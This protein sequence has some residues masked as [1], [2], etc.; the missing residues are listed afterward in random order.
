[1]DDEQVG[2]PGALGRRDPVSERFGQLIALGRRD[3]AELGH[4]AAALKRLHDLWRLHET[5]LIA[6]EIGFAL[7]EVLVPALALPALALPMLDKHEWTGSKNMRLRE[8][9]VRGQ[10]G[11]AIDAV[12]RRGKFRQQRRV[13]PLQAKHD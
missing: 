2:Q 7:L 10:S 8:L 13:R 4:D 6:I 5:G 9:R 12:P 3:A 1:E 11:C